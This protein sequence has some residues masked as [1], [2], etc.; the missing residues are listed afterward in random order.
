MQITFNFKN[1]EPS[2]QL[3]D[4]AQGRF[5]KLDKYLRHPETAEIQVNLEVEKF[6]QMA[7]VTLISD[8]TQLS[9]GYESED[10]YSSIDNVL[11][12]LEAQI[13]RIKDRNKEKRRK[14]K[15]NLG[16]KDILTQTEADLGEQERR[17]IKIDNYEPKPLDVQEAA[18]QL[19][20]LSYDFLVF[21]NAENDR[22]NVIY[23]RKNGD[24]GLIDPG[25]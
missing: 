4:Y 19:E 13:R 7:D 1:F 16:N 2:D 23:Q 8:E 18:L 15:D 10:M 9:A 24:F 3:K 5:Q 20:T 12:K 6:R 22:V 21:Q 17:I 14:S 11:D 25:M